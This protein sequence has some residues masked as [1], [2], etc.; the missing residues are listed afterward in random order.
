[1][2]TPL[3]YQVQSVFAN[4]SSIFQEAKIYVNTDLTL[5]LIFRN[6]V[7]NSVYR[8]SQQSQ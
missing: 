1:M 5:K 3:F 4:C 2:K 8:K 6:N 7:N